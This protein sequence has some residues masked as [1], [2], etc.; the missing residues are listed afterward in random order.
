MS[1]ITRHMLRS[2]TSKASITT[3]SEDLRTLSLYVVSRAGFSKSLKSMG[4]KERQPSISPSS[5]CKEF[6]QT[7]LENC[8][9]ILALGTGFPRHPLAHT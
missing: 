6:L 1:R 3:A 5:N 8:A 7:I 2:W 4:Q 9:V